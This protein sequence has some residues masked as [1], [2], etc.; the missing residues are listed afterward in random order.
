M[1]TV[2]VT[3]LENQTRMK[4]LYRTRLLD[5]LHRIHAL[6]I[7]LH[8]TRMHMLDSCEDE[9]CMV[10][11]SLICPEGEPLHF[12]HDGCPVCD[13]PQEKDDGIVT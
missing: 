7:K 13:K 2:K 8:E 4:R 5:A 6:E 10:C 12:H 9:E 1:E 3:D 11:G